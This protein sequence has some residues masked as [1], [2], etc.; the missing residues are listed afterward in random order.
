MNLIGRNGSTTAKRQ[1]KAAPKRGGR[2]GSS[3]SNRGEGRQQHHPKEGEEGSTTE[4]RRKPSSTTRKTRRRTTTFYPTSK[5]NK[6]CSWIGAVL[7]SMSSL[8]LQKTST[9]ADTPHTETTLKPHTATTHSNHTHTN[10]TH[11]PKK[12]AH[13]THDTP[14]PD[15]KHTHKAH[16]R[17]VVGL[18]KDPANTKTH[19]IFYIINRSTIFLFSKHESLRFLMLTVLLRSQ[20]QFNNNLKNK[21]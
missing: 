6:R 15:T 8:K 21:K 17:C 16:C 2:G 13:H 14:T 10:Q 20:L 18:R 3:T 5:K 19:K 12:H 9:S 11:K 7:T 1:W 4:R